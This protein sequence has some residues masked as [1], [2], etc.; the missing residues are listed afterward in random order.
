MGTHH[1][2]LPGCEQAG[3]LLHHDPQ[4]PEV[5]DSEIVHFEA[6]LLLTAGD[7]EGDH[8]V[9]SSGHG[10][11]GEEYGNAG[12]DVQE[13]HGELVELFADLA[14]ITK[15]EE[16]TVSEDL[17]NDLFMLQDG[18]FLLLMRGEHS[19]GRRHH[20]VT[21]WGLGRGVWEYGGEETSW[22]RELLRTWYTLL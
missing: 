8:G 15:L 2:P 1:H 3:Q 16:I 5:S 14:D 10:H 11:A 17:V 21:T 12:G 7:E 18:D 9:L 13:G 22:V 6:V 19:L 4:M 20:P